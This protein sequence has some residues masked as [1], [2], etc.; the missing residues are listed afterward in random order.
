MTTHSLTAAPAPVTPATGIVVGVDTHSDIHLAVALDGLGRRLGELAVPT[1]LAGSQQLE[2][3]AGGLGPITAF[4]VE[5]TGSWGANLTRYLRAQ[6]QDVIE[7][8]RPDRS[9]RRRLWTRGSRRR[10]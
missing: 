9:T 5:G 8:N 4:G 3:W 6:G 7:V 10:G 1:T 2:R